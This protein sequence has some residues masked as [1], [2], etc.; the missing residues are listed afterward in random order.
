[1]TESTSQ[2]TYDKR[3]LWKLALICVPALISGVSSY[4]KSRAEATDQAKATFE[5]IEADIDMLQVNMFKYREANVMLTAEVTVLK[6]QLEAAN[7]RLDGIRPWVAAP[8][9]IPAPNAAPAS[10]LEKL[11]EGGSVKPMMAGDN[12]GGGKPTFESIV[13]AYKAKK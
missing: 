13:K 8:V 11:L 6:G 5:H 7:K 1:M 4:A 2:P 10:S 3:N 9:P 12:S